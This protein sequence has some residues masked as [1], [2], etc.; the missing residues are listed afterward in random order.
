MNRIQSTFQQLQNRT[1]LIGYITA[2]DP[3]PAQTVGLMHALAEGG[4]DIIEL[5]VPFSDPM[6]DG[7][8]IQAAAE[9]A[10]RHGTRLQD[11]LAMVTEFR[12]QN[13]IT[14]VVLMGYLNPIHRMGYAAFALAAAH[15]GVDGILTVDCP[16]EHIDPLCTPLRAHGVDCIFLVAPTT[17]D[18]RIQAIAAKASGFVYYVSLK[19]VTGSAQLDITTVSRKIEHLRQYIRL[20]IGVGF[21]IK[22][23]GSAR[24]LATVADAVIVGSRLVQTVAEHPGTEA[25]ALTAVTTELKQAVATA[26]DRT[27]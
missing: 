11:V 17:T 4:S 26:A 18:A 15:A 24:A 12:R 5:G 21:G 2:G 9:R 25:A 6:A 3:H 27:L 14:P 16:V 22:D 23:A 7:P 10:L 20:P 19:G 13:T 8:V 1:A